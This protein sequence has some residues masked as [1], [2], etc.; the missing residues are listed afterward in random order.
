VNI[1]PAELFARV[2]ALRPHGFYLFHNHPSGD[3]SPSPADI[4]LT[5]QVQRV[6]EQLGIRLLGH[7]IVSSREERWIVL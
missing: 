1:D 3:L 6:S 5:R 7:G 4:D 2:L